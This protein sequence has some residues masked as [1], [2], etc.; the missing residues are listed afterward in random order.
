MLLSARRIG[1]AGIAYGLDASADMLTPARAN[2]SRAGRLGIS[3]VIAD[4]DLDL[5]RRE[6]AEEAVG[7][8]N[9]TLTLA[10]YENLLSPG[11]R[12]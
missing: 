2:V 5:R 1:P 10:E 12:S 3:D 7:C 9:G 6:A 11:F 8:T 4:A